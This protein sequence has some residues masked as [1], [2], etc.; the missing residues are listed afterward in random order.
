MTF[1]HLQRA[2]VRVRLSKEFELRNTQHRI[3]AKHKILRNTQHET[4][5]KS[6]VDID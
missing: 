1:C 5:D 2:L 6:S 4:L 3:Y